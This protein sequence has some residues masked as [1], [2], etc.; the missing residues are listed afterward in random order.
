MCEE[1]DNLKQLLSHSNETHQEVRES[2][3]RVKEQYLRMQQDLQQASM[4]KVSRRSNRGQVE[5]I[6]IDKLEIQ[7]NS[8][9]FFKVCMQWKIYEVLQ[10]I[11]EI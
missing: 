8:Q 10:V 5:F 2:E 4:E 6:H 9:I 1:I 7:I 3:V 11:I